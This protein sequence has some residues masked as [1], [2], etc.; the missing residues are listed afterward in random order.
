LIAEQVRR[1]FGLDLAC[2][3]YDQ[4]HRRLLGFAR[5]RHMENLTQYAQLLADDVQERE[6]FLHR[7]AINVSEFF[8]DA[9]RFEILANELLPGVLAERGRLR[10]WS[11]GCS[12]GHE[13]YSLAMLLRDRGEDPSH[14]VLAT[15]I[16][17]VALAQARAGGPYAEKEI[18]NMSRA[19]RDRYL[20]QDDAGRWWV[21]D[22][23]R[24]MVT[25]QR[26]DLLQ[27]QMPAG[28]DM[29]VCRN[30]LIYFTAHARAELFARFAEALPPGGVLFVGA[31]EAL[32]VHQALALRPLRFGFYVREDARTRAR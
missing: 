20:R 7:F 29:I 15:D 11:A 21:G 14:R 18:R 27:D 24:S 4:L 30:V 26:H 10:V 2:Y 6:S 25:F 13:P 5:R 31:T 9:D 19:H 12:G 16:D 28:F 23:L 3:R 22:E 1:Y 8:R 17:A 32:S